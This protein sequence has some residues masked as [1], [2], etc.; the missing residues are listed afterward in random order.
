MHA[1]RVLAVAASRAGIGVEW[2]SRWPRLGSRPQN[3]CA[4]SAYEGLS[5]DSSRF[6]C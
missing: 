4:R 1:R 2:R 6:C 5:C 3:E